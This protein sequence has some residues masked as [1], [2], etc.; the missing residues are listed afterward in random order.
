MYPLALETVTDQNESTG[1]SFGGPG[2]RPISARPE[3]RKSDGDGLS[4]VAIRGVPE[5][6]RATTGT[7][8]HERLRATRVGSC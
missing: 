4:P 2:L 8:I 1:K 7:T 5:Q 6:T 3:V